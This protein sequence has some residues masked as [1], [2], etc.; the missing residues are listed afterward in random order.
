M[1][2]VGHFLPA[3]NVRPRTHT[4]NKKAHAFACAFQIPFVLVFFNL[5]GF[6]DKKKDAD[7]FIYFYFIFTNIVYLTTLYKPSL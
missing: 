5:V 7:M 4:K 1:T 2:S 3:S 6:A